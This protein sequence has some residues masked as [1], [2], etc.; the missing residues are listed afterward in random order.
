MNYWI[1]KEWSYNIAL[2]GLSV[3]MYVMKID[4][5]NVFKIGSYLF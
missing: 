1:L 5:V 2:V 4:F 3:Y